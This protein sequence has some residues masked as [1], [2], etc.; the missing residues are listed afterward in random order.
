MGWRSSYKGPTDENK[1]ALCILEILSSREGIASSHR[2]GSQVA[3]YV[4]P[5]RLVTERVN[6]SRG[7]IMADDPLVSADHVV[8]IMNNEKRRDVLGRTARALAE[9]KY[10]WGP[11]SDRLMEAY[12][13][14]G[15][16]HR[17]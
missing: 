7:I 17:A 9:A 5:I 2:L 8:D 6:N 15:K 14:A 16:Y 12:V 4:V 3:V 1:S 11:I 13:M 10:A